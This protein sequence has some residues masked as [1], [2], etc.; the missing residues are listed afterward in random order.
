MPLPSHL[1]YR[2]CIRQR[3][4]AT[5]REESLEVRVGQTA[6][7]IGEHVQAVFRCHSTFHEVRDVVIEVNGVEHGSQ[8]S[9]CLLLVGMGC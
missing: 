5:S 4:Q 2:R 8:P 3:W 7:S 6:N 9:D 1:P